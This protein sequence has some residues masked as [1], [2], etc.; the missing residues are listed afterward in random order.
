MKTILIGLL[1][2][3]VLAFGCASETDSEDDLSTF[4]AAQTFGAPG[5]E[6]PQNGSLVE[7]LPGDSEFTMVLPCA[8]TTDAGR[9]HCYNTLNGH[10]KDAG[11]VG[12]RS[13]LK[14][15][16]RVAGACVVRATQE[17]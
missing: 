2:S 11:G 8:A 6:N 7:K 10:C 4:E 3:S 15:P 1:M 5:F 12:L 14:A 13:H 17:S 9:K 16:G